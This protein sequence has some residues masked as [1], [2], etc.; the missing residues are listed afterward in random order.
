MSVSQ[1]PLTGHM[2]KSMGNFTTSSYNGMNTVRAKVFKRKDSKT[3]AQI[4]H[5][6]GFKLVVDAYNSMGGL[7]EWGFVE[8]KKNFSAYNMFISANYPSAIDK[9]G[10]LPV[11][12]YP[13][14]FISKG[15]IPKV[16]LIESILNTDSLI[17]R[18]ETSLGLPKVS[19]TDEIVVV[20][21]YP[22]GE[23]LVEK[24]TR[25]SEKTGSILIPLIKITTCK[26]ECCYVFARSTDGKK[27]SNSIYVEL[28]D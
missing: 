23:L 11:L 9:T 5:R 4:D 28:N 24:Q 25:G 6:I 3:K 17:I 13:M 8:R 18:Y 27:A 15:S 20:A 19:E 14:L 12:N 21:K 7:A 26:P 10:E 22:T 2:K 16:K 1:N